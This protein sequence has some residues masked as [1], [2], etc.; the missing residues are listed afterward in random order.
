MSDAKPRSQVRSV[1]LN[2]LHN[3]RLKDVSYLDVVELLKTHAAL[4]ATGNLANVVLE[5]LQRRDLILKD[6]DAVTDHA[7]LRLTGDLTVL[8]I[9]ARDSVPRAALSGSPEGR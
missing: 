7:D 6:H 9:R 4:V 1:G 2:L 3:E 5:S 8:N